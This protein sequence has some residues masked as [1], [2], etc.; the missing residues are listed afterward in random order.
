MLPCLNSEVSCSFATQSF[1]G[2]LTVSKCRLLRL[3]PWGLGLALVLISICHSSRENE[4][5]FFLQPLFSQGQRD[6]HSAPRH[7]SPMFPVLLSA[8]SALKSF[9]LG[10]SGKQGNRGAAILRLVGL[11]PC[12]LRWLDEHL[13]WYFVSLLLPKPVPSCM[14]I[15]S[16][17][18][19]SN[20]GVLKTDFVA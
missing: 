12:L 3:R 9:S 17:L 10:Y 19:S 5:M 16:T 6:L 18:L 2:H 8:A 15:V 11:F 1:D 7:Y 20:R 4:V 13:K 14:Q